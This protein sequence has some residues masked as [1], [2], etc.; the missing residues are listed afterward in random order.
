MSLSGINRPTTTTKSPRVWQPK[1]G[2]T[3]WEGAVVGRYPFGTNAGY[4]DNIG[5]DA[6]LEVVGIT[7]HNLGSA[8]AGYTGPAFQSEGIVD[9]LVWPMTFPATLTTA[10]RDALV[11]GVDENN[12]SLS[13]VGPP[14]GMLLEVDSTTSGRVGIG[15]SWVARAASKAQGKSGAALF[16]ARG[17]VYNN[18]ADLTAFTVASDDGM[19]YVAGDRVLL[20]GQTTAA[21]CGLYVV[22]TVASTTAPLTR[23]PEMPTGFALPLGSIVEVGPGGT[24][25]GNSTWKATA[26][27]TGG[28]VIGTND[29]QFYPRVYK[30]TVNLASGT[31]TI[32]FGS[33]ANPDEPL[34]LLS[35]A[36]VQM[37]HNT[38]GGTLGTAKYGAP[39]ASRV[40]GKAGTA[41]VV[42]NSLVDAGTVQSAD[43]STVDVL[44]INW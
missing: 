23:A 4:I 34:F 14:I 9:E 12:A 33:T 11:Y 29:P 1:S 6:S 19:T 5:A 22:G 36:V 15:P 17:V 25:Y 37:G 31:Y 39:S 10:S 8:P 20:V 16:K 28:P 43:T 38:T 40:T 35:G 13:P 44:I 18:Q 27:T 24:F 3:I 32:G 42:I 7:R 26:T 21:Q 30:Q 2:V 41:V